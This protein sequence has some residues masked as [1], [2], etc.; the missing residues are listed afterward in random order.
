VL[1]ERTTFVV[2]FWIAFVMHA[3][4]A[5]VWLRRTPRPVG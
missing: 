3:A 4:V 5:E 2:A 1:E